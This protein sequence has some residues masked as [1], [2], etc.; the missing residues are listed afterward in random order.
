MKGV[1][2]PF[3]PSLI[4]GAFIAAFWGGAMWH[5]YRRLMGL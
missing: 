4:T 2:M 3:G 5:W 1:K